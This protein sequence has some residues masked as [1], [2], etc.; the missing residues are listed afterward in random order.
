MNEI[1]IL[2]QNKHL[3][4]SRKWKSAHNG[5]GK[6][7]KKERAV[8][9][10]AVAITPERSCKYYDDDTTD[11]QETKIGPTFEIYLYCVQS[12]SSA[13]YLFDLF[14]GDRID[15][16]ASR[17]L[18]KETN[19]SEMALIRRLVGVKEWHWCGRN[20]NCQWTSAAQQRA[21]AINHRF[22]PEA[23]VKN[24]RDIF[25]RKGDNTPTDILFSRRTQYCARYLL[26]YRVCIPGYKTI[27]GFCNNRVL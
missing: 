9:A 17:P 12:R 15:G 19:R 23:N 26:V 5:A 1:S 4:K 21:V 6:K 13:A 11:C 16:F 18:F 10:I 24:S 8:R 14:P 27:C 22:F 3:G 25:E 7:A 2:M 20:V